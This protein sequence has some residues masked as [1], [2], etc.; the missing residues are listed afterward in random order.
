MMRRLMMK[1]ATRIAGQKDIKALV[2][3]ESLA[4]VASQ[5]LD[6]LHC[7]DNATSLVVL[8]PLIGMDKGEIIK[9]SREIGTFDT[10]ILPYEDC[11]TVFTPRHPCT[12]PKLGVLEKAEQRVD[13]EPLIEKAIA[14]TEF[15]MITG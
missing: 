9:I 8:R 7:T 11:C 14:G 13:Y 5:T 2:T 10:S 12:K 15:R 6:A 4:Q 3:G 1:I